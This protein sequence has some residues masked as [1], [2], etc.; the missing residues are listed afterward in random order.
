[1]RILFLVR[2]IANAQLI[3][4]LDFIAHILKD[5]SAGKVFVLMSI[6]RAQSSPAPRSAVGLPG[7][8]PLIEEPENS[9]LEIVLVQEGHVRECL[10]MDS[11][12][13]DTLYFSLPLSMV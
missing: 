6:S 13:T 4:S 8:P 10:S 1:M 2:H 7:D 11:K 3:T 5:S 12:D 9:G